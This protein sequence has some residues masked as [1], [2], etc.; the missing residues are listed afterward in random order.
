MKLKLFLALTMV[1]QI[2]SCS[3]VFELGFEPTPT[4]ESLP[5]G[6]PEMTSLPSSTAT[7]QPTETVTIV[8]SPTLL[9][10]SVVFPIT[11]LGKD[12]P[13]LT[14]ETSELPHVHVITFN[15]RKPPFDN[16]LVRKAFAAS[17]DR[18]EIVKMAQRWSADSMLPAT[19]FI[20]AQTLGRDLYGV[21]G[22][23]YDPVQAKE[24]LIQA[25]YTDTSSFPTVT[26][27]VNSYGL[28]DP[29]ARYNMASAMADM[30]HTHLG[31]NVEVQAIKPPVFGERMRT[32]PPEIFWVGWVSDVGNDPDF[33][34][35]I[36]HSD[37]QYNY[38]HF[39]NQDFDKLVDQAA[40]S[41]DPAARQIMYIEAE[42]LLC[43]A[44]AVIVPLYH[45]I[46]N[47]P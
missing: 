42:R 45:I 6:T 36:F 40:K 16:V 31:V 3:F 28:D 46:S 8:P 13:W 26:F 34:R 21:V 2:S 24:W 43:E 25:G 20:P 1:I 17:I 35:L 27:I 32:N 14:T 30:W 15:T 12:I 9:P 10:G 7:I 38:G 5:T 47:G 41:H 22:I 37:T 29:Y 11:S 44:E 4:I 18:E 19:T 23:N 39:S 33:I